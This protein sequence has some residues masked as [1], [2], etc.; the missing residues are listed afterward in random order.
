MKNLSLRFDFEQDIDGNGFPDEWVLLAG[1]RHPQNIR[2]KLEAAEHHRGEHALLVE[3]D[4]AL[5]VCET[6]LAYPF[7]PRLSY[8]LSGFIKTQEVPSS[9]LRATSARLECVGLAHDGETVVFSARTKGVT[10]TSDWTCV[11]LDI[12]RETAR[13][14]RWVR[15][16]CVVA[17]VALQG[18]VWFDEITLSPVPTLHVLAGDPDGFFSPGD[19]PRVRISLDTLIPCAGRD[20]KLS[21]KLL[22]PGGAT[23]MSRTIDIAPS[24]DFLADT[25]FELPLNTFGVYRLC[26]DLTSDGIPVSS[27][28]RSPLHWPGADSA[29]D[30]SPDFGVYAGELDRLTPRLTAMLLES[31]FGTVAFD[32]VGK[33]ENPD[34]VPAPA[35]TAVSAFALLRARMVQPVIVLEHVPETLVNKLFQE[36]QLPGTGEVSWARVLCLDPKY[37]T[38]E[39]A[40]AISPLAGRTAYWQIG[41]VSGSAVSADDLTRAVRQLRRALAP[42]SYH[43]KIGVTLDGTEADEFLAAL[44]GCDFAAVEGAPRT[45]TERELSARIARLKSVAR[46]VWVTVPVPGE[47]GKPGSA[48]AE[49]IRRAIRA[50]ASGA[51]RVMFRPLV[52]GLLDA[53][54]G[55]RETMSAAA[56][57]VRELGGKEFVGT[58]A[59]NPHL[60][61]FLGASGARLAAIPSPDGVPDIAYLGK[62]PV[63]IDLDGNVTRILTGAGLAVILNDGRPYF[64][65]GLDVET[66]LKKLPPKSPRS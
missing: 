10:G 35:R 27:S 20:Y 22:A 53:A 66:L 51:D 48:A 44:K 50:R 5:T 49:L 34:N 46:E 59:N 4:G 13:P 26:V 38:S 29:R 30:V 7:D 9:G 11:S 32:P 2:V 39:L 54:E 33:S 6:T 47:E 28:T 25:E 18:K 62:T 41:P 12:P 52:G 45:E 15:I 21:A 31:R 64:V 3:L 14:V 17:G 36:R 16:R 1:R 58:L 56:T 61:L 65:D 63:R 37:W 24:D 42:L 55:G 43:P 40:A 23:V 60:F 8:R 19:A 57:L